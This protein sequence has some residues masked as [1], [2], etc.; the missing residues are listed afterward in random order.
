MFRVCVRVRARVRHSSPRCSQSVCSCAGCRSE[1]RVIRQ[2]EA[3]DHNAVCAVFREGI[4]EHIWPAFRQ[5]ILHPDNLALTVVISATVYVLGGCCWCLAVLAGASWV[6]L[7]FYCCYNRFAGY[8]RERLRTDMKDIQANFL[9]DPDSCFWVVEA[10]VDGKPR[11][12]G[13]VAVAGRNVGGQDQREGTT[14]GSS[15]RPREAGGEQ[16]RYGEIFRMIV[17]S[18]CRRT[19]L[20]TQLAQTAIQFCQDRKFSKI[21]LHTTSVQTAAIALY[22]R[23]GFEYTPNCSKAKLPVWL[24]QLTKIIVLHME[25]SL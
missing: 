10:Q 21:I 16:E 20:G 2:Y 8:V 17:L 7:V 14:S 15:E 25:K 22:L 5:A 3:S 24:S 13:M 4:R 19:G 6:G 18:S 23:L 9:S 1:T 12:L 11:I